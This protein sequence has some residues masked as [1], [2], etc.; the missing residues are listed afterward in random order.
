VMAL[1]AAAT[2]ALQC[3]LEVRH[4]PAETLRDGQRRAA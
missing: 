1:G 3:I 4:G 2:G